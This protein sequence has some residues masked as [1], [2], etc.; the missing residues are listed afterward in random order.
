MIDPHI[1][2]PPKVGGAAGPKGGPAARPSEGASGAEP[3]VAFRALLERLEQTAKDLDDASNGIE[4]PRQLKGAVKSAGASVEEALLLGSDLVEAYR[5]ARQHASA[6][7]NSPNTDTPEN[8]T[9]ARRKS[10]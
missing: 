4:D 2:G 5:A 10:Q 6:E 8:G 7:T 3:G 9:S 1:S